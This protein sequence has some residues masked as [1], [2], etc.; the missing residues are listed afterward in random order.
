MLIKQF[1]NCHF[2]K[3]HNLLARKQV[4]MI[5]ISFNVPSAEAVPDKDRENA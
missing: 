3:W 4:R 2:F 5:P 1:R